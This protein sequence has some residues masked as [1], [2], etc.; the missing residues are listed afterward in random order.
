MS[1]TLKKIKKPKYQIVSELDAE[2]RATLRVHRVSRRLRAPAIYAKL[3]AGIDEHAY[4]RE[5]G[6]RTRTLATCERGHS[7]EFF[8]WK[9]L[10]SNFVKKEQRGY[11]SGS[12]KQD[13]VLF[14]KSHPHP[15]ASGGRGE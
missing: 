11:P 12:E 3:L 10:A 15:S 2:D 8:H 1:T 7:I 5:A 6:R 4:R 13:V 14:Y 9:Q